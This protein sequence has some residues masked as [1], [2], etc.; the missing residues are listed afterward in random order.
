MIKR[1]K[2]NPTPITPTKTQYKLDEGQTS[3]SNY[4]PA[5]AL[6]KVITTENFWQ[7][8]IIASNQNKEATAEENPHDSTFLHTNSS[9]A[10]DSQILEPKLLTNVT[11]D[12]SP[13]NLQDLSRKSAHKHHKIYEVLDENL[14]LKLTS[15]ENSENVS[16]INLSG[17]SFNRVDK[18][19][20]EGFN[21]CA[22]IQASRTNNSVNLDTFEAFRD[23]TDLELNMSGIFSLNVPEFKV[24]VGLILELMLEIFLVSAKKLPDLA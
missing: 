3:I 18:T 8:K 11:P 21:S 6:T 12:F 16:S 14:I 15:V 22:F 9:V 24:G 23:L 5:R 4:F 7:T 10:G 17:M 20:F 13:R 2:H 1:Q 19:N